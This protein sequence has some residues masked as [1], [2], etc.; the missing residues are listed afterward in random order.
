[1]LD[2][3]RTLKRELFEPL[4][5]EPRG[6]VVKRMDDGWLVSERVNK[7]LLTVGV[8]QTEAIHL[9]LHARPLFPR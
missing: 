1:M 4:V 7:V 8:D 5:A 3:L 2:A 6:E 9:T